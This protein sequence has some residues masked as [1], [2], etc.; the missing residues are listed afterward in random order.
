MITRLHSKHP[1]LADRILSSSPG[2]RV[3][4]V[5]TAARVAAVNSGLPAPVADAAITAVDSG[6]P[7]DASVKD[8]MQALQ[9]ELD[10]IYLDALD[11]LGPTDAPSAEALRAFRR[12]RALAALIYAVNAGDALQATE[13][14]Y[15]ALASS[16][17]EKADLAT[18]AGAS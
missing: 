12:A 13:V 17:D 7:L 2:D 18:I 14:V 6:T 16:E 10:N 11:A 3:R 9:E 8:Q 15:E 4:I 5:R 1:A